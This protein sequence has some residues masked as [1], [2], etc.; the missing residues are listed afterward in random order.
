MKKKIMS[1]LLIA[2]MLCT[3]TMFAS[4]DNASAAEIVSNAVEKTGNL[5][6]YAAEMKIEIDMAAEGMTLNIP[7]TTDM[8]VQN[9]K[10]ENPLMSA[11]TSMS[12]LGQTVKM[13][14]YSD[15]SW[16]YMSSDGMSY[17]VSMEAAGDEYDYAGSMDD[18][19]KAL[20]ED[21]LEN[22]EVEKN[23]DGSKTVSAEIPGDTFSEIY[24][25][26]VESM[27]ETSGGTGVED[28]TVSDAKVSITVADDYITVYDIS[29][30]MELTTE[31][32]ETVSEVKAT[33]TFK[34]PGEEVAVTP[35]EGYQ[36]FEE[37]SF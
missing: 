31:G 8:K 6:S 5:N 11:T 25:D 3:A 26:L 13:D 15:G 34:N 33:T 28:L 36:D 19:I 22:V 14:V 18:M 12:M 30:K 4:C 27:N 17:K 35:M 16:V 23:E 32:I 7:M 37:L 10:S 24:G 29:F 21:L 9:A 1:L 2:C 20:P